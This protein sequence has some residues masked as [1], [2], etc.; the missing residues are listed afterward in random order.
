MVQRHVCKLTVSFLPLLTVVLFLKATLAELFF[1]LPGLSHS[2]P[3][4]SV[5]FLGALHMTD[6]LLLLVQAGHLTGGW[7]C[8]AVLT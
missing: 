6:R 3:S 4:K 2:Y 1:P 7:K 8:L 5:W